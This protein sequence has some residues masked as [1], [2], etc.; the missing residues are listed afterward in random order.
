MFTR[1]MIILTSDADDNSQLFQ[2]VLS[3]LGV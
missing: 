1:M 2:F 3:K